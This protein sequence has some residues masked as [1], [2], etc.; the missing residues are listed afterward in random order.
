MACMRDHYH[1]TVYR[2]RND[3]E[4]P[5]QNNISYNGIYRDN[6]G[7][8]WAYEKE[9]IECSNPTGCELLIEN[10]WENGEPAKWFEN[11]DL[12]RYSK[13]EEEFRGDPESE[14]DPF[15]DKLELEVETIG[16]MSQMIKRMNQW[17]GH[18]SKRM[19]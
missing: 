14:E 6:D 12:E 13:E 3:G 4:G 5:L 16:Q 1:Y 2:D 15:V 9:F 17:R 7:I 10:H 18:I 8:H 11:V 19:N